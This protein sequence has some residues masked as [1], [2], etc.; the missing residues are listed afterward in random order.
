MRKILF[1]LLLLAAGTAVADK[2]R[3]ET[4]TVSTNR[5]V[6]TLRDEYLQPCRFDG[7][8]TAP[9]PVA[10]YTNVT[11]LTVTRGQYTWYTLTSY[12]TNEALRVSGLD[13]PVQYGD[14]IAFTND[15]TTGKLILHF[16]Q[17]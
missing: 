10:A 9:S 17:E 14:V 5:M 4:I 3:S 16:R 8:W 13:L 12:P 11:T 15:Y 7:F 2:W 6:L 1:L